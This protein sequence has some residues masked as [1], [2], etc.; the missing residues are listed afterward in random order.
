MADFSVLKPYKESYG[1]SK[2]DLNGS[3][4]PQYDAGT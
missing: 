3:S 1:V 2:N 4:L